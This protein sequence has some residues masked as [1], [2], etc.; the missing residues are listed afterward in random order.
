MPVRRSA[1]ASAPL[2]NKALLQAGW[3]LPVR[4]WAAI[5]SNETFRTRQQG[6]AGR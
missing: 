4:P 5:R 1:R 3:V 6:A 2:L